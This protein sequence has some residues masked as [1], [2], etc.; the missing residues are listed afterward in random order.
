MLRAI[1]ITLLAIPLAVLLI[2]CLVAGF[3]V[4]MWRDDSPWYSP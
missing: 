1:A 4:S 2:V 3:V